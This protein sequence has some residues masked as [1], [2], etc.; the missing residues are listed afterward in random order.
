MHD[1][2]DEITRE[3]PEEFRRA[4]ERATGWITDYFA[5]PQDYPVLSRVLPGEITGSFPKSPPRSGRSFNQILDDFENTI[6]PGITHWNH[7]SFFAYFAITGS[8]PGILGE[9][10]SAA[11]NV[12][13][14]LWKTSPAVTEL[15]DV[16]LGYL[17]DMLGLPPT[18]FGMI[19]DTASTSSLLAVAAARET[20]AD[21]NIRERGMAGRTDI[22]PL[23]LYTSRESHSSIEK[24]AIV[25]GVGQENV[26]K[27]PTDESFR[28]DPRVLESSI[29][30]DLAAGRRPFCVVATVGTTSTTSVDPV[31]AIAAICGRFGIWLHV[32]AAY[33]GSAAILPEKRDILAGCELADSF[34]VNPHKWLM[35]PIDLSAFYCAKP[36][37]LKNAFSLVPEYLRTDGET[38]VTNLMDY[39][40][41]LGRRFRALKLW[42]VINY[43]GIEGLQSIIRRHLH[44][45]GR[46]TARLEESPFFELMAPVPFSTICFR[47]NPSPGSKGGL[48]Q[49]L[50]PID[51]NTLDSLNEQLLHAINASGSAYL[52][53]TK[54]RDHFT[55][56]CAIGN[57]RTGE[58]HIDA[59]WKILREH[60]LK[61]IHK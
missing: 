15:E 47:F 56:R 32:D 2:K 26:R 38:G 48:P 5:N 35:T 16:A 10:L 34:V 24:A 8:L 44:L 55:L 31:P 45:A 22:P 59:L 37:I 53:H 28:M 7:P 27:I 17:R 18:F 9:Y 46:L 51:E 21:L 11:L 30:A 50:E 23:V 52:S 4:V 43:F 42:M 20:L 14:M 33:A 61:L 39:G 1:H 19:L 58:E 25:L 54:I 12:N 49:T 36:E 6:V 13:G 3:D 29:Q 57:L 40:F 60:A 41:Q